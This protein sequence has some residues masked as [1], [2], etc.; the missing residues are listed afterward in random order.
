MDLLKGK[1]A[2]IAGAGRGVGRAVAEAYAAE[3]AAVALAARTASEIE[4]LASEI[5]ARG[6]AAL[7]IPTDISK[8]DQVERL[9]ALAHHELGAV[10]ILVTNAAAN[11][12]I[13]MVWETNPD[14]W[15][16][17]YNIN[18]V[19]MVR[20]ARA[21]LPAMIK[22]RSGKIIIVGSIAGYSDAWASRRPE[23]AAYGLT[24]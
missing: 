6:G 1:V 20:C 23:H 9:F 7:A 14:E 15:L 3:G 17:L 18:V 5:H 10:D 19:G 22:R 21:A 12:P 24:K 4:Q 11:G 8:T 2:I 13:G 16:D